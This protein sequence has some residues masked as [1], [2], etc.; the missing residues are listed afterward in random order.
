M[1]NS[2]FYQISVRDWWKFCQVTGIANFF[3]NQTF[4]WVLGISYG[5]ILAIQTFLKQ[6]KQ[7]SVNNEH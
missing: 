6:Q 3:I 1:D 4:Y 5:V 7:H 2:G